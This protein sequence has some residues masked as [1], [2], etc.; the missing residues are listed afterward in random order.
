MPAIGCC[1]VIVAATSYARECAD[2][3]VGMWIKTPQQTHMSTRTCT[4]IQS[5][6]SKSILAIFGVWG[7]PPPLFESNAKAVRPFR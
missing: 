3:A 1:V 4:R 6:D 7:P 2:A 5:Y